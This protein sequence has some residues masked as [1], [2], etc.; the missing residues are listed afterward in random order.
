MIRPMNP[1]VHH[2]SWVMVFSHR[3]FLVKFLEIQPQHWGNIG[4]YYFA[5]IQVDFACKEDVE[6]IY[7]SV[8]SAKIPVID[9]P[10]STR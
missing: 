1:Q 4:I 9:W 2:D 8:P 6:S 5:F 3:D 10:K 7:W